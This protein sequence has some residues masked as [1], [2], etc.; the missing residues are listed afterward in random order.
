MA[1][2]AALRKQRDYCSDI[3]TS[4]AKRT[5]RKLGAGD[6]DISPE[7]IDRRFRAAQADIRRTRSVAS[8]DPTCGLGQFPSV[9]D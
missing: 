6:A 5:R 3:C 9:R 4:R 2:D 1:F 8:D 7:E